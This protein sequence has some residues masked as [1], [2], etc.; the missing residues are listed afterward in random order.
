[1]TG[2]VPIEA[3]RVLVGAE[4]EDAAVTALWEAGTLGIEVLMQGERVALVAYFPSA[5]T[6][7]AA[8]SR[9]IAGA[10]V[11]AAE[12]P[13]LDWVARYREGFRAFE[14]AGFRIVPAWQAPLAPDPRVL[15]VDPGRAF[16]TGTHQTTRLCLRALAELASRPLRR[17]LDLGAGTGLLGIAAARLGAETVVAV[18]L[19]PEAV[20]SAR[21]HAA[22]NGVALGLVRGDGGRALRRGAFDLVLANLA[23]PLLIDRCDE[24]ASLV[25]CGGTA[26]LSGL[27]ATEQ[28]EVAAAYAPF[29]RVEPRLDGEWAAL[30]LRRSL[31]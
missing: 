1:V 2:H 16:G 8:L 3:F 28:R 7:L 11:R 25:A 31:A 19:D 14:V 24:V 20:S 23:A 30:V 12:V 27:L 4:Q 29:G 18:D 13:E 15:V 6:S 17:V 10:E 9:S 26:V 21:R 22:L 5:A